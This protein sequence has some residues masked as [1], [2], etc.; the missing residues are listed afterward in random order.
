MI[1][2]NIYEPRIRAPNYIKQIQTDLKG[3]IDNNTIITLGDICILF[4]I[5]D[6][7]S[8]WKINKQPT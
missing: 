3:E 5:M 1:I 2:I 4:S 6:R 7:T 8:K